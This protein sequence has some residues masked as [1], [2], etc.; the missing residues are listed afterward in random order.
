MRAKLFQYLANAAVLGGAMLA[1]LA[2]LEFV[3][4][5]FILVP[6]DVVR[7]VSIDGVVRYAPGTRAVF[8]HPDGRQTLVTVN[9]QGWNST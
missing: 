1:C 3:V 7:N 2:F 4:F 9:Q 8:R 6:D 5:A